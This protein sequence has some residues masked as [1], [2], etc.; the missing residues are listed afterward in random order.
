MEKF[1]S[2][3]TSVLA[4]SQPSSS[5][6]LYQTQKTHRHKSCPS[7]LP[8]TSII[9]NTATWQE[10]HHG[11]HWYEW[12]PANKSSGAPIDPCSWFWTC[13]HGDLEVPNF[14]SMVTAYTVMSTADHLPTGQSDQS[15]N[16]R[17]SKTLVYSR[18]RHT[19]PNWKLAATFHPLVFFRWT[20]E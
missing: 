14:V 10:V 7:T 5:C 13:C 19:T 8:A 16:S 4:P 9:H 1:D 12:R 15:D 3:I 18:H 17:S 6:K 2:I 11:N 20:A